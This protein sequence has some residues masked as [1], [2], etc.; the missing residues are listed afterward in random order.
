MTASI[1]ES[2]GTGADENAGD[3]GVKGNR[4][5]PVG[6]KPDETFFAVNIKHY[7][8]RLTE[9]RKSCETIAG[10]CLASIVAGNLRNNRLPNGVAITLGVLGVL[11]GLYGS[12]PLA[13]RD[14]HFDPDKHLAALLKTFKRRAVARFILMGVL[15]LALASLLLDAWHPKLLP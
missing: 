2:A 13:Q 10:W 6:E 4:G 8:D 1:A 12:T 7:D 11:V 3:N 9:I 5:V 15:V 14:R